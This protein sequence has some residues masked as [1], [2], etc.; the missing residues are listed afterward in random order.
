MGLFTKKDPCAICGGKVKGLFAWSIEGRYICNDC[1]GNVD[2]PGN[3]ANHMT[4]AEFCDYRAF[5]EENQQLKQQFQI[6]QEIDFGFFDDK[7]V[8]DMGNKLFC[9]DKHLNK[10]IFAGSQIRSFMIKEDTALLFEGS[11]EGLIR[12]ESTVPERVMNMSHLFRMRQMQQSLERMQDDKDQRP[13]NAQNYDIPEPFQKFYVEIELDHPYWQVLTID[14]EGPKFNNADPSIND[15]LNHYNDKVMIM[16]QLAQALMNVAF[17]EAPRKATAIGAS[18]A[19]TATAPTTDAV[20]EIKRFKAL[21]DQGIITEEEFTA[22][23]RQL[24][25]I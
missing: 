22:K 10:T 11:A 16:D 9:L 23:K 5:R 1:Y 8:F 12:H 15:Y 17:S 14:M 25:G 19:P 2:L 24:L 13:Q 4:M 3:L 21:L 6:S 18:V 20:E 7:L